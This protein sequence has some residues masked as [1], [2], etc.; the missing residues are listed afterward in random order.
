MAALLWLGHF[1]GLP[2]ILVGLITAFAGYTAVYALNDLVDFRVDRRRLH[3]RSSETPGHFHVDEMLAPHPVAQGI[4]SFESALLWF[5]LWAAVALVGAWWLNPLCAL[6]FLLSASLEALYCKLLRITHWKIVPSIIVKAGGG[7]AG[8]LAVDPQPSVGFLI[9]LFLWLGTWEVG[10][11]NVAN[12]IVDRE[13]DAQ[14]G[15]KTTATVLG[16]HNAVFILVSSVSMAA[17]TGVVIYWLA[18]TGLSP[19]YPVGAALLGWFLLIAPARQVFMD[20]GPR[21]AAALFNRASH[22]PPLVLGLVVL[23]MVIP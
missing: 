17:I 10:G 13:D 14:V 20:P 1:P 11:Q 23:S 16:I 2:V 15:A 3:A 7:F 4:L 6:L 12:D 9:V 8:V 21:T 18:G 19:V 22:M 5:V